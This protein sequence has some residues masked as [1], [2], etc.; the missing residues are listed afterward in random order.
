MNKWEKYFI[1][2]AKLCAEQSTCLRRK[3]GAVI[4][5]NNS[6]ISTG[7]NGA[8]S[9]VTHCEERGCLRQ[10]LNIPSGK[11]HELCFGAHAEANAIA[12]A[13]RYGMNIDDAVLYCTTYPCSQC[14]KS[15]INAG[16]KEIYYLD[17]Y[18]D[19]ITEILFKESNIKCTKL[20]GEL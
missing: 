14:A 10:K 19:E 11:N 5:K 13:A 9:K 4:V 6:S 12:T 15:I 2:I 20:E 16:I 18:P 7:Y 1:N 3:V 17:G 8:P